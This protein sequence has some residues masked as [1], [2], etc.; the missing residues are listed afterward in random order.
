MTGG[1]LTLRP[2]F[3]TRIAMFGVVVLVL[4]VLLFEV[5]SGFSEREPLRVR[6]G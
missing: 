6:V 4:T 2:L 5:N 1:V 3:I